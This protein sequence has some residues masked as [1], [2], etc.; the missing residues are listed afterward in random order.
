MGVDRQGM[1]GTCQQAR[2]SPQHWLRSWWFLPRTR[3]WLLHCQ[4]VGCTFR[5]DATRP[6]AVFLHRNEL[7]TPMTLLH[8]K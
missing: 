2:P 1:T 3:C 5:D 7:R 8:P 4:H 6:R